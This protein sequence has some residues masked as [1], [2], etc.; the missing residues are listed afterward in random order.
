MSLSIESKISR[1]QLDEKKERVNLIF[2]VC[3]EFQ[4][5]ASYI[6]ASKFALKKKQ[7]KN[8]LYLK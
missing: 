4:R 1:S 3:P 6:K 5:T 7:N 8:M 2:V